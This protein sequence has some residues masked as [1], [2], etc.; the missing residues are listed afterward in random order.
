M[1]SCDLVNLAL[2]FKKSE[3]RC[4]VT[5]SAILVA[6]FHSLKPVEIKVCSRRMDESGAAFN[7]IVHGIVIKA[8]AQWN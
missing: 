6:S 1:A 2:L 5:E 3:T 8:I 4:D 7:S